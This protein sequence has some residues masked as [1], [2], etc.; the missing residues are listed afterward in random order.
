MEREDPVLAQDRDVL[1]DLGVHAV[2]AVGVV[3]VGVVVIRDLVEPAAPRVP[4][5][6]AR[7]DAR[8]TP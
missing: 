5:R 4:G 7:V 2:E 6:R 8:P 3:L 1:H